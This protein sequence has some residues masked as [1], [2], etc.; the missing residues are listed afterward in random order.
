MIQIRKNTFETNS[1]SVHTICI[2][3]EDYITFGQYLAGIKAKVND[4][5]VANNTLTATISVRKTTRLSLTLSAAQ[6]HAMKF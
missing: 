3:N 5:K 1:S 6:S 4:Y 2:S